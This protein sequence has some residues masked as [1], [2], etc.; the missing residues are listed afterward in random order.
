MSVTNIFPLVSIPISVGY[1]NA[2]AV[3]CPSAYAALPEPA[4][5]ATVPDAIKYIIN[6]LN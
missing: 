2:A 4:I 1:L 5:V 3:P 6:K